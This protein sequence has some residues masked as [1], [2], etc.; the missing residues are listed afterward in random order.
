MMETT[1]RS[2]NLR[3]DLQDWD[4]DWRYAEY[5]AFTIDTESN[6]FRMDFDAFIGGN[7][8]NTANGPPTLAK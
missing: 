3:V 2:Y 7:A 4:D 8:G 5:S 1:A 6:K